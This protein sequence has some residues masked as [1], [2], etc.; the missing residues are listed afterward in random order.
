MDPSSP[1][2]SKRIPSRL[3]TLL[4]TRNGSQ[5]LHANGNDQ[6]KRLAATVGRWKILFRSARRRLLEQSP[7]PFGYRPYLLF[8]PGEDRFSDLVYMFRVFLCLKI[9]PPL[10]LSRGRD[11]TGEF[12]IRKILFRMVELVLEEE[13]TL[14]KCSRRRYEIHALLY[15]FKKE[16]ERVIREWD[17]FRALRN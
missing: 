10:I 4:T 5:E 3:V 13:I 12:I 16:T 8:N 1:S 6:A 9:C 7:P 11:G 14:H 2:P 15:K 17:V